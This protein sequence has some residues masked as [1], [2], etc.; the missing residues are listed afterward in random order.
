MSVETREALL[1]ALPPGVREMLADDGA[2]DE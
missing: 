1:A 2:D